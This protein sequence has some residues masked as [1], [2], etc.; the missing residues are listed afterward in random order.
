VH[1]VLPG[2]WVWSLRFNNGV[3]SAGLM[4][5]P[6][7][8]VELRLGE[9]AAAWGRLLDRFPSLGA[10][11]GEARATR[12]FVHAA[13]VPFRVSPVTSG[14]WTLLPSAAGFVDPLLS[15]G[16]PLTLLGIERLAG[17]VEK[18]WGSDGWSAALEAYAGQTHAEL[19]VTAMLVGALYRCMGDFG[20]FVPLTL[21]YFAAASFSE[22]S[23]RLG[24]AGYG[25]LLHDHPTFGPAMRRC[26][27][28]ARKASAAALAEEVRRAIE[29]IDIAGLSRSDRRNWYP[30]DAADT[31]A[32]CGKL[33]VD[34]A[35]VRGMLERCGLC[36]G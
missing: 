23:R 28:I 18:D 8:A 36:V 10:I 20:K 13:G 30:A 3:T 26:C 14:A 1:H 15:T 24:R 19:D 33:G 17:I 16:F 29:P 27:G 6:E 4:A 5:T 7:M 35:A 22:A 9:G 12:P 34:E 2:G 32:A 11:F 21:L 31:L 25:F